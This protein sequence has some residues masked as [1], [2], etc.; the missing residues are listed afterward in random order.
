MKRKSHLLVLLLVL[1][2][3]SAG[4]AVAYKASYVRD[5]KYRV[6]EYGLLGVAKDRPEHGPYGLVPLWRSLKQIDTAADG[7]LKILS[8]RYGAKGKWVDVTEILN[9]KIK[10]GRLSVM[11][12]NDLAGDPIFMT[13]KE[14][15]IEYL[16]GDRKRSKTVNEDKMVTLP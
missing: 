1:V 3:F 10:D 9:S 8:A 6:S 15:K 4:C 7:S 13:E 11:A 2:S 16:V 12:S 5:D 14:L